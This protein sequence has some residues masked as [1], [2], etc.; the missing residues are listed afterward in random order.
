M[1]FFVLGKEVILNDII[2][3]IVVNLCCFISKF[4]FIFNL[5][6][7]AFLNLFFFYIYCNVY[8]ILKLVFRFKIL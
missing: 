3:V 6:E 4:I 1:L 8:S 2:V 5:V 7:N